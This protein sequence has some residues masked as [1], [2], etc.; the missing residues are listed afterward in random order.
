MTQEQLD[1]LIFHPA[2]LLLTT[3]D[4]IKTVR[5]LTIPSMELAL[6]SIDESVYT[7]IDYDGECYKWDGIVLP[8]QKYKSTVTASK[9][10]IK[11]LGEVGKVQHCPPQKIV[12]D[13]EVHCILMLRPTLC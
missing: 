9:K 6:D 3:I 5:P 7:C 11:S 1:N 4:Y 8:S 2:H 13:R 12:K 10:R